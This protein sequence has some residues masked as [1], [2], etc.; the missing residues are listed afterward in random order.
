TDWARRMVT[1]FGFSEKLGPLRYSDNEEEVF[2]GHSVTQRK[3]VSDATAALIDGEIRVIIETAEGTARRILVE[4][5]TGLD[6]I[7]EALLE[8]ETLSGEE[9]LA[10]LRG[11]PV[12]R[13][14]DDDA[15]METGRRSSVPTSG[16]AEAADKGEE[17]DAGMEPEPQP[18]S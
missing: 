6:T 4:H 17:P 9:V 1:E 12:F 5:R 16:S 15:P 3:N 18:G 2:L 8:F 13:P 14:T 11:E 7:A 10:L